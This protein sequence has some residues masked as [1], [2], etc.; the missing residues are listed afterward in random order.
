MGLRLC[1][2]FPV[3][4]TP[5]FTGST[6]GCFSF[7]PS[8]ATVFYSLSETVSPRFERGGIFTLVGRFF[9]TLTAISN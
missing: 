8:T 2:T 9:D 7:K 6:H 1:V 5:Y 4:I 3:T